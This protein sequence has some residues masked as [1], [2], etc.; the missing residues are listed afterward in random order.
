MRRVISEGHYVWLHLHLVNCWLVVTN[1]EE[2]W[3]VQQSNWMWWWWISQRFFIWIHDSVELVG[4]GVVLANHSSRDK[5]DDDD[6]KERVLTGHE[7]ITTLVRGERIND[8]G[9]GGGDTR[10]SRASHSTGDKR[11]DE[12]LQGVIARAHHKLSAKWDDKGEGG[13]YSPIM[14]KSQLRWQVRWEGYSPII[15]WVTQLR[16]QVRWRATPGGRGV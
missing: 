3:L 9:W 4:R 2:C 16:W 5:H 6:S 14:I 13:C 12:W 8:Y 15:S 1:C 11:H 7:P 10:R